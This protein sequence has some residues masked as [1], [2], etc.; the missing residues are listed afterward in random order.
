MMYYLKKNKVCSCVNSPSENLD[1]RVRC[2]LDF[3]PFWEP[4]WLSASAP[5]GICGVGHVKKWGWGPQKIK[6]KG[7]H[8]SHFTNAFSQPF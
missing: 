5:G 6:G 1:Q 8:V 3:Q 7:G 4:G 2:W